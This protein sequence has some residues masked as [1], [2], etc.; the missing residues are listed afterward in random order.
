LKSDPLISTLTAS[1][2]IKEA[3]MIT[4]EELMKIQI[5]HNQGKSQREIANELGV[6][7]NTLRRYLDMNINELKYKKRAGKKSKLA[8]YYSFIHSRIAQAAPVRLVVI[9]LAGHFNKG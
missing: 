7:R 2:Q 8:P 4:K 9:E 5:L 6:S 1:F 3:A